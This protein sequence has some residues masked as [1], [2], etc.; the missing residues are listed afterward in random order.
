MTGNTDAKNLDCLFKDNADAKEVISQYASKR[1]QDHK[2]EVERTKIPE[3]ERNDKDK[4]ALS[5]AVAKKE[6]RRKA[7]TKTLLVNETMIDEEK[8]A[9]SKAVAKKEKKRLYDSKRYA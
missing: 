5:K 6:K 7:K 3:G 8:D 9:L 1:C 2:A 4:E